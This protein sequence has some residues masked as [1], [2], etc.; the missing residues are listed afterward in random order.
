MATGVLE[1]VRL[2]FLTTSFAVALQGAAWLTLGTLASAHRLV[3]PHRGDRWAWR[4]FG[5]F[6]LFKCG[7]VLAPEVCGAVDRSLPNEFFRGLYFCFAIPAWTCA[8]EFARRSAPLKHAAWSWWPVLVVTGLAVVAGLDHSVSGSMLRLGYVWTLVVPA[9][10]ATAVVLAVRGVGT[11]SL[12]VLGLAIGGLACFEL[13]PPPRYLDRFQGWTLNTMEFFRTSETGE[14]LGVAMLLAWVA[15][16]AW[17]VWA[18][19]QN[20]RADATNRRRVALWLL[21]ASMLGVAFFGFGLLQLNSDAAW[22]RLRQLYYARLRTISLYLPGTTGGRPELAA[23]LQAALRTNPDFEA[24]YVAVAV[25]DRLVPLASSSRRY[26]LPVQLRRNN[27][28][29]KIVDTRYATSDVPLSS[30]P[31]QDAAGSFYIVAVPLRIEAGARLWLM[32]RVEL[33]F[34]LDA[35]RQTMVQSVVIIL[36]AA[37]GCALGIIFVLR[38]GLDQELRAAREKAD[39]LAAARGEALAFV[40]HEL[41]T[42]LQSV[43]GYAE[44]FRLTRMNE[45]QARYIGFIESQARVVRRLVDAFLNLAAANAGR[46]QPQA[47][48]LPLGETIE[49]CVEIVRP[50]AEEKNLELAVSVASDVPAWV[51]SDAAWLRQILGNVLGNAVKFTAVGRVQL[52]VRREHEWL[53]FTVEDTGRGIDME[54]QA[55]LFQ[56]F[57]RGDTGEPGTG[58]GLAVMRSLCVAHGGTVEVASKPGLGT[59]VTIRLPMPACEP[60]VPPAASERPEAGARRLDVLLADDHAGVRSWT[61]EALAALG[62]SVVAVSDGEAAVAAWRARRFDAVLIDLWLPKLDGAEVTR[63]ILAA[64]GPETKPRLIVFT[65]E[66]RQEALERVLAAGAEQVVAKPVALLTL[67]KLFPPAEDK[68]AHEASGLTGLLS[69]EVRRKWLEEFLTDL[70]RLLS[71]LRAAVTASDWPAMRAMAHELKNSALLLGAGELTA[72]CAGLEAPEAQAPDPARALLT[73]LEAALA[74]LH[75]G[76]SRKPESADGPDDAPRQ[77]ARMAE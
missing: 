53:V 65:A 48:P 54:T 38:R 44:L 49:E 21:P 31:D 4:W 11:W 5:A 12:R 15:L 10:F 24:L 33:T 51:R 62:H 9:G 57:V 13:L 17:W 22:E 47:A 39:A 64:A 19:F 35:T 67:A 2:V 68:A 42:P 7:S 16:G 52:G 8:W 27:A 72:V 37:A 63:R 76:E 32:A 45:V 61:E 55:R 20:Q 29:G 25:D 74:A 75:L 3:V 71:Q 73:K 46:L 23:A 6:A 14:V 50:A 59:K 34:W 66:T 36:L 69:I 1:F 40:S 60:P 43:L 26:P 77:P 41:R 70:P 28:A 30:E 56:L 58:V 18:R